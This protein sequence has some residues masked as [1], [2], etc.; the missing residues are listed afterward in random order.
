MD[1]DS[2]SDARSLAGAG[3]GTP[4]ASTGA[5][6]HNATGDST[7]KDAKDSIIWMDPSLPELPDHIRIV[8]KSAKRGA[9]GLPLPIPGR[10]GAPERPV[11]EKPPNFSMEESKYLLLLYNHAYKVNEC[12]HCVLPCVTVCHGG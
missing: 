3:I 1:N 6:G 7:T 5:R 10:D 4:T 11:L 12:Q 8:Y 9:G 2:E